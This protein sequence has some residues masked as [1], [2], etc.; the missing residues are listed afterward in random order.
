MSAGQIS[1]RRVPPIAITLLLHIYCAAEPVRW[2]P[3]HDQWLANFLQDGLI[4]TNVTSDS[5]YS[6]TV[7]GAGWVERILGTLLPRGYG[8][9]AEGFYIIG[10]RE[11]KFNTIETA[12]LEAMQK[13]ECARGWHNTYPGYSA[14]AFILK[15]IELLEPCKPEEPNFQT[16]YL[17]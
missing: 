12:R 11:G 6:L 2:C 13:I 17:S 10:S 5:G 1:E 9:K 16:T 8:A 15:A 14:G 7:K 3:A 4:R